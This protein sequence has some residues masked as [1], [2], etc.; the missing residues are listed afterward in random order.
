MTSFVFQ[1]SARHPC[2]E[3]M[4]STSQF[5][6]NDYDLIRDKSSFQI[7]TGP[8][9]VSLHVI[10]LFFCSFIGMLELPF[11]FHLHNNNFNPETT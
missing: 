3:L 5:I 4:D 11:G 9:M 2:V 10:L 7:I 8:N 1:Q 6:A